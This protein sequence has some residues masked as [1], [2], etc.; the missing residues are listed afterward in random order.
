MEQ[1]AIRRARAGEH[2]AFQPLV[3]AYASLVWRTARA[4]LPDGAATEDTVQDVWL[5]VWRGLQSFD[6]NRPF[7]PWLL[8]IVAN[9]CRMARRKR[10]LSTVG[11]AEAGYEVEASNEDVESDMI[12]SETDAELTATL[13][14]LPPDQR[15]LI[16]L[17]FFAKL[18]VSEIALVL[19]VA[20][21]T[22]KS[23]L[24]RTLAAMRTY[25]LRASAGGSAGR[26][27]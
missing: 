9:R 26:Q 17:R 10:A 3:E 6:V 11:F 19:G 8:A 16:E 13:A 25:L 23:R 27:S 18:S 14:A 22:V 4:L 21:G 24:S 20:E 15:R 12:R 2:L 5:D 1:E 7:R